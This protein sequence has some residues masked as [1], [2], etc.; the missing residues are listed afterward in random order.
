MLNFSRLSF[1][2]LRRSATIGSSCSLRF[3]NAELIPL[4]MLFSC[5]AIG[6]LDSAN[7][8]KMFTG[9][10]FRNIFLTNIGVLEPINS[11]A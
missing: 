8:P 5:G 6:I 9:C 1:L 2:N 10:K 7:R 3:R 11:L 4:I